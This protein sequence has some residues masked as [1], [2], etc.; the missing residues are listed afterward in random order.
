MD[1]IAIIFEFTEDTLHIEMSIWYST[2]GAIIVNSNF[3]L[4]P[5]TIRSVLLRQVLSQEAI[6]T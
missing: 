3:N 4:K 2:Y 5:F 1:L 6:L